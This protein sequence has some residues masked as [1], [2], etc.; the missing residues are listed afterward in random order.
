MDIWTCSFNFLTSLI[1]YQVSPASVNKLFFYCLKALEKLFIFKLNL[2]HSCT[3]KIK[4]DEMKIYYEILK[5]TK[6]KNSKL[7]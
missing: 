6:E 1:C 4:Q 2:R 5:K 7:K 3:R